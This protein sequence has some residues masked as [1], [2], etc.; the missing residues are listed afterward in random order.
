M[1][2]LIRRT[3][4]N[5]KNLRNPKKIQRGCCLMQLSNHT[6]NVT[7]MVL[8]RKLGVPSQKVQL[9]LSRQTVHRIKEQSCKFLHACDYWNFLV[10]KAEAD[11]WITIFSINPDT[12]NKANTRDHKSLATEQWS[13][14]CSTISHKF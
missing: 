10:M 2:Q 5:L 13:K 4:C 11:I 7:Q 3:S 1:N 8:G 6:K 9:F 14:M 12:P